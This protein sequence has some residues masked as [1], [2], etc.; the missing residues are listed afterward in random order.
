M[1]RDRVVRVSGENA[2]PDRGFPHGEEGQIAVRPSAAKRHGSAG[3][4]AARPHALQRKEH[5]EVVIHVAL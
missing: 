3:E 1:R 4:S 5:T 2:L